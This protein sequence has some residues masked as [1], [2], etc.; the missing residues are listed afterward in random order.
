VAK[1]AGWVRA[2]DI[3]ERIRELLRA[4]DMQ[5]Q[6]LAKLAGVI[7]EQVSSWV[8][9]RPGASLPPKSRLEAI[10]RRAG[11]PLDIFAE[12]GRRPSAV[13]VAPLTVAAAARLQV[14]GMF[15]GYRPPGP[16]TV[17][18][19]R[20]RD[21]IAA[22]EMVLRDLR[23]SIREA[24]IGDDDPGVRPTADLKAIAKAQKGAGSHRPPR[25]GRSAG[26][27]G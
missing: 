20:V 19:A 6:E 26:G 5:Q 2:Q 4:T 22:L 21:A 9:E 24:P 13:I 11:L 15:E 17:D 1:S 12:G 7:P 8:S 3:R 25:G 23:A 14:A 10:A 18:V 16:L 27:R